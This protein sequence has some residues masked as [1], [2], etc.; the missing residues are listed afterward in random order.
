MSSDRDLELI[1]AYLDDALSAEEVERLDRRLSSEPDL[2]ELLH[3]QRTS[4]AFRLAAYQSDAPRD[5]EAKQLSAR[6]IAEVFRRQRMRIVGRCLRI[7]GALA[8]CILFGFVAG[9]L[10]RGRADIENTETS[11]RAV[12]ADLTLDPIGVY[13]VSLTDDSGSVIDVRTFS[14][15]EQARRYADDLAGYEARH[16]SS[17]KLPQGSVTHAHP[18]NSRARSVYS[19]SR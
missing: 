13:Q 17:A 2:S 19:P 7:A 5:S 16:I 15:Y 4:R 18:A 3:A 10:G 6:I 14:Q 8:A 1:E 11:M 12:H 9:W